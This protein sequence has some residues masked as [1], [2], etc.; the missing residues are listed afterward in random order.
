MKLFFRMSR[1]LRDIRKPSALWGSGRT[2]FQD[3]TP[4]IA[5]TTPTWQYSFAHR[6]SPTVAVA[7]A[8]ASVV[9]Y[10]IKDPLPALYMVG[11]A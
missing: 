10:V 2:I 6:T 8:G 5:H 9:K 3:M 4:F 7:E 1:T 11:Y